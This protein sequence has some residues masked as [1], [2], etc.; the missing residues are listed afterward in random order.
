MYIKKQFLWMSPVLILLIMQFG[1]ARKVTP[2]VAKNVDLS[3][4]FKDIKSYSWTSDID[5]IPKDQ[6]FTGSNGVFIFN[7]ESAR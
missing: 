4:D 2:T 1:C 5:N 7:N 6:L 3:A